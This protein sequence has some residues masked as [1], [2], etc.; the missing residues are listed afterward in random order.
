MHMPRGCGELARAR[1]WG[2]PGGQC[3]QQ[4]GRRDAKGGAFQDKVQFYCTH[5]LASSLMTNKRP[6]ASLLHKT[7]HRTKWTFTLKAG[8]VRQ[9]PSLTCQSRPGC[10]RQ[11]LGGHHRLPEAPWDSCHSAGPRPPAGTSET[12][13]STHQCPFHIVLRVAC[14][15]PTG[16]L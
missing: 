1:E 6:A 10:T 7:K 9:G 15:A 12:C 3:A 2:A 11:T 4:K 14:P 13:D 8:R 5:W 16:T